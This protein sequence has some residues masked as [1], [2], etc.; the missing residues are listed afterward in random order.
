MTKETPASSPLG[1]RVAAV[2]A[3]AIALDTLSQLLWKLAATRLP[4]T[5]SPESLLHSIER[6]PLPLLV[7]GVFLLQLVNWLLVLERVDLSYAQ[8][9][10]ALSYVSVCLLSAWLFGER[11][12]VHKGLGVSLV[13]AG[14]ALVSASPA[15][16][17]RP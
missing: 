10:T 6:D 17:E 4:A 7:I 3:I 2:L 11:L 15:R 5:L 8:P 9:L 1:R 13:L 16:R 14:V 12:D